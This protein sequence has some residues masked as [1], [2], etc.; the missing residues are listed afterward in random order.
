MRI[1]VTGCTGFAGGYLVEGLAAHQPDASL[2][3]ISRQPERAAGLPYLAGKVAGLFA[4]DLGERDH[5]ADVLREVQP[6]QLFHLAGYAAV[7]RSFQ[8]PDAAWQAN[9]TAARNLFEAVLHWGG[10]PRILHVSSGLVYGEPAP[11]Q[12]LMSEDC[13]LRPVSPYAASKAAADLAAFQ[14]AQSSGL[15]IVRVRP[16]NHIG[17][18]QSPEFALPHF[19][20]QIAAIE[21]GL[22]PPFVE[23]G[24]LSPRRDLTDVRDMVRAYV[25]LMEKGQGGEVYN[26]GTG[27]AHSMREVLDRL[28]SLARVKVEVRQDARL[29]RAKETSALR[30][31]GRKLRGTTGW[32]PRFSLEQTLSDTLEYWRESVVR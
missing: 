8:E 30:A 12:P 20:R 24:D 7:G 17:P 13:P 16:F 1:L 18:R 31:D 19:A 22:Q 32:A 2:F 21:R 14:Y 15:D 4:C 10:R 3:G 25:L 29:L 11:S 9:L 28:L 6:D 5:I 26:V 27:E 23:T